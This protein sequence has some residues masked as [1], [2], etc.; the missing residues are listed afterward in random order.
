MALK[1]QS[2][3]ELDPAVVEAAQAELSQL[4]QERHPEVELTRGVIHD[5]IAFFSGGISGGINQTEINRVLESRSLLAIRTNPQLSD[6]MLVDHI[7]SNYLIERR[8]GTRARGDITIVVEGD[9]T[10]VV[11]A[12]SLYVANGLNYRTDVPITARPPGTITN[13]PNDRVLEPRGDGSY[14]FAVPATAEDVGEGANARAGTKFTPNPPP[15]RFVTA[16]GASDFN[17][18]TSTETNQQ[19]VDRMEAGIPAKVTAGRL[20]IKALVKDQPVFADVKALSI[21]GY[22]DPE[23][24]RDQHWIFPVS[25]GGRIDIYAQNDSLPQTVTLRKMARLIDLQATSSVWQFTLDRNDAPGFYE[26]AAVRRPDDPIDVAG[27]ELT[28]D[29]RGWD[30]GN[31]TWKP[32]IAFLREAI[33]TRYQTGVFRFIDTLTPVAELVEGD[34]LEYNVSVLTQPFIRE[35]QEFLAGSDHR[36]LASDILVKGAIPAF[37]AINCDIIKDAGES[38]PDL[39]E[40]RTALV[41]RV[42][43]LNFPGVLYASQ[44][45]DVIHD[46]L[47]GSQAVGPLDLHARIRRVDGTDAIVRDTAVLWLPDS[48]STLVTPKTTTFIL[49]PEDIG[50]NVVNRSN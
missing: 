30:F 45:T 3:S 44:I 17:G 10:V 25:G 26:V 5:I 23:M 32:D 1:V 43:N 48:P 29:E 36:S 7:L 21:V 22:A 33:Y 37:L 14:E 47:S 41:N 28:H 19:I 34:E 38:A 6:P 50:L 9:S 46:Y 13:D 24:E 20:N 39:D 42:N 15:A 31:D 35:M 2:I 18:G 12:N 8:T 4:I 11:S 27:F 40:I 49:Y 16:F